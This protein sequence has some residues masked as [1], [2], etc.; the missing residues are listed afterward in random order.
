MDASNMLVT[1]LFQAKAT[2]VSALKDSIQSHAIGTIRILAP[3]SEERS[4]N[5]KT[6]EPTS[7]LAREIAEAIRPHGKQTMRGE[8]LKAALGEYNSFDDQKGESDAGM[9]V[10]LAA[11]SKALRPFAHGYA[12]PMDLIAVRERQYFDDGKYKGTVYRCT[13]L[14]EGVRKELN[15]MN[16]I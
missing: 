12:S 15:E 2:D 3:F 10:A 9:R 4:K 13:P 7:K 11:L 8:A 14:G 6:G 1:I 5:I 16:V